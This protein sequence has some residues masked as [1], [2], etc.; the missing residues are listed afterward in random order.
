[1]KRLEAAELAAYLQ[2]HRPRLIDVREAWEF[3][4]CHIE[5]SE[6]L[7]MGRIPEAVDE[8]QRET[9]EIVLICHHGIRS[10]QVQLYLARYGIDHS[11]N[12]EGG[13]DA[14]A[15][16]VDPDMPVY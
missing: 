14:W 13:V 5:G 16:T 1:M 6:L 9:R 7:P 4:I 12:L 8:L 2:Q 10:R 11:I 3:E 15:R